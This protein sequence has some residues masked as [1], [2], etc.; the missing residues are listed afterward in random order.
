MD[1]RK[2]YKKRKSIYVASTHNRGTYDY[3]TSWWA[4]RFKFALVMVVFLMVFGLLK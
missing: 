3:P 4:W 1:V 2:K